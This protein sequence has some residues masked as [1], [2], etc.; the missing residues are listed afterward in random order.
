[1]SKWNRKIKGKG[2]E[3]G[4]GEKSSKNLKLAESDELLG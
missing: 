2:R 4:V 1:M 3:N